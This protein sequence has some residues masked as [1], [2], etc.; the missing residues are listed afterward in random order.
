[1]SW[2]R[3]DGI[4]DEGRRRRINAAGGAEIITPEII[5]EVYHI[6]YPMFRYTENHSSYRTPNDSIV[7]EF[8]E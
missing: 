7:R 4:L 5:Q 8:K 2:I 1:V 3:G 6:R